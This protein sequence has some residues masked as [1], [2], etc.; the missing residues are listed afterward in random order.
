V[1]QFRVVAA[2]QRSHGLSD[3]PDDGYGF[4]DTAADVMALIDALGLQRPVIVGHSWGASVALVVAAANR[5]RVRAVVLVDGGFVDIG[6]LSSWEEAEQRMRPPEMDGTPVE[7]FTGF[8]KRWPQIAAIW[9]PEI[10]SIVMS[11]FDVRDGKVYRR[12]SIPNHMKIAHAI[13]ETRLADVIPRLDCPLLA[14]SAERE[15][16]ND[17]EVAWMRHRIDGLRLLA[18]LAPRAQIFRMKDT[19]HDV[20]VQRPGELAQLIAEF[21]ASLP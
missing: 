4:D 18:E 17:D 16:Q 8:I 9:T 12:L 21:A 3:R 14:V 7:A 20:P 6:G 19:I 2:D 15:P 11:N 5:D 1:P 13:W 10:E